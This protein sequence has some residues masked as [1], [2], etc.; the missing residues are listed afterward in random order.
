VEVEVSL[1][2]SLLQAIGDYEEGDQYWLE[3]TLTATHRFAGLVPVTVTRPLQES[4]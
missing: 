4:P 1:T 2:G 3:G